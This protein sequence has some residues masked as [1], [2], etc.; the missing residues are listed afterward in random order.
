MV[1]IGKAGHTVQGPEAIED[2]YKTL[3]LIPEIFQIL[4][5]VL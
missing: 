5:C 2:S 1:F 3:E 4:I